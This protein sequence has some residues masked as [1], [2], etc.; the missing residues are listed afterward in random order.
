ML[1]SSFLFCMAMYT[2]NMPGSTQ[3]CGNA[4]AVIEESRKNNIPEE[5]LFALI[6]Y[7]SRWTPR[8][9]SPAGACGLTQVL[10]RYTKGTVGKYY[11]CKDLKDPE[12]AIK[13]GAQILGQHYQSS[14]KN[15]N[16]ALCKYN[17]GPYSK[18][19]KSWRAKNHGIGY[20]RKISRFSKAIKKNYEDIRYCL[21]LEEE[22]CVDPHA[23]PKLFKY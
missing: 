9:T 13:V 18:L 6:Y 22:C 19:C 15:L 3:A 5:V 2:L 23:Q 12:T 16:V 14:G 1:T 8:V 4:A 21:T 17:R 20:A 7:E 11:S 10:P